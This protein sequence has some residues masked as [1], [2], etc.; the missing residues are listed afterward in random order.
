VG[1][2][3]AQVVLVIGERFF[4]G[5]LFQ[6]SHHCFSPA[7]IRLESVSCSLIRSGLEVDQILFCVFDDSKPSALA[8]SAS[9]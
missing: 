5:V 3:L 8:Y 1:V 6:I 9:V 7:A 4:L 2:K